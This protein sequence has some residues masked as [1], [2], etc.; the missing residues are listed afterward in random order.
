M[1]LSDS[2]NILINRREKTRAALL[3]MLLTPSM[4]AAIGDIDV[5]YGY[6]EANEY[7]PSQ[8]EGWGQLAD[9]ALNIHNWG[10]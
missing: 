10:R 4:V 3:A 8:E 5:A 1:D 7:D 9:I 6:G 2:I